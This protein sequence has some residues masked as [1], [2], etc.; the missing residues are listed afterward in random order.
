[1]TEPDIAGQVRAGA[2]FYVSH[3]GG[4]DSQT[5]YAK[6]AA[7][8]PAEQLVVVHAHLGEIEWRGVEDHIRATIRHRLNVVRARKTFFE[9]VRERARSRPEVPSFP[10]AAARQCTSDLKRGPI[11]KF[12]RGD[13][14]ARGAAVGINCMGLRAEESTARKKMPPWNLNKAL[15]NRRRTVYKWLP[16]HEMTEHEVFG[17]IRAIGQEPF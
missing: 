2:I 7:A 13:M 16:I 11:Y 6:L 8:V 1:M 15:S 10:S 17:H 4:K 9:M 12:I 5:M 14:K 3:S